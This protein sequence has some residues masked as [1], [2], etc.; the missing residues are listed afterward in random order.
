MTWTDLPP[1][2]AICDV[3]PSPDGPGFLVGFIEAHNALKWTGRPQ[4]ERR[5][6]IVDRIV[7]F[8]GPEAAHPID[9][10]D[11]DWPSEVWTRGCYG[12]YMAP[13]VMTTVG[14]SIRQPHGRI[15]WAGTETSTRWMGY[16]DGA[17]RSGDRAAAEVLAKYPSSRA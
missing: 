12:A 6:L 2:A 9:Y 7:S 15:H 1:S 8:F 4:E 13:G 5:K 11:Q 16:I 10:E 14:H 3:S 17:L